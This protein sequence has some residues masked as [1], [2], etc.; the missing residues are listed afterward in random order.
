M[1]YKKKRRCACLILGGILLG[2][3]IPQASVAQWY[4]IS[5][6]SFC[7][8]IDPHH[9]LGAPNSQAAYLTGPGSYIVLDM[10]TVFGDVCGS[11]DITLWVGL[12]DPF[13]V[14][15]QLGDR[16]LAFKPANWLRTG[17]VFFADMGGWGCRNRGKRWRYICVTHDD[18]EYGAIPLD[19]V[20]SIV[21]PAIGYRL[22]PGADSLASRQPP[23]PEDRC[24]CEFPMLNDLGL[25]VLIIM[26]VLVA[27]IALKHRQKLLTHS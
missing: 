16:N 12:L 6:Y 2:L 22:P 14:D 9:A 7:G 23:F 24:D 26:L 1:R 19:A 8:V 15:I 10:D 3:A 5:V 20:E 21:P 25:A 11:W 18:P 17:N 27:V 13:K 4:A